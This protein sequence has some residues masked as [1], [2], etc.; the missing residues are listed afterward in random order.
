MIIVN[1]ISGIMDEMLEFLINTDINLII[2]EVK[3]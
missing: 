2:I 3:R 1:I